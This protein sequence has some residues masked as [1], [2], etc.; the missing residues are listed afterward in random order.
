VKTG[1]RGGDADTNRIHRRR[2]RRRPVRGRRD[3]A[4]VAA[5]AC[6]GSSG[7]ELSALAENS[8]GCRR[9]SRGL[10]AS[11]SEATQPEE[12]LRRCDGTGT[13]TGRAAEAGAFLP[14]DAAPAPRAADRTGRMCVAANLA[15]ALLLGVPRPIGKRR[16]PSP[17]G[18]ARHRESRSGSW[19]RTPG[20]S[21]PASP[22][23]TSSCGVRAGT[24]KSFARAGAP[25]AY[26]PRG[27]RIVQVDKDDLVHLPPSWIEVKG[28]P[29]KSSSSPTTSPSRPGSRATRC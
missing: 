5:G 14:R 29:H 22:R 19:R 6:P 10:R 20:N 24:G 16:G 12:H 15:E 26:A 1:N 17:G 28:L 2:D 4:T 25:S 11:I 21:S 7:R 27:L 18:S 8:S 3:P 13:G 9:S 23:T